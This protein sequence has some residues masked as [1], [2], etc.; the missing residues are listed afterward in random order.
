MAG[1]QRLADFYDARSDRQQ[2]FLDLG[3]LFS[4]TGGLVYA[5]GE[6]AGPV[7]RSY[8]GYAGLIPLIMADFNANE[9]TRDLFFAGDWGVQMILGR[10]S[11]L[12]TRT[13][14]L[15]SIQQEYASFTS[16]TSCA[17]LPAQITAVS[18]WRAGDDKTA[19]LAALL[20]ASAACE[21]TRHDL[22]VLVQAI[23]ESQFTDA[24]LSR[25]LAS[26]L[27]NL[28]RSLTERDNTLRTT[29]AEALTL[30]IASPLRALDSLASGDDVQAAV[31]QIRLQQAIDGLIVDLW[32]PPSLPESPSPWVQTF[33]VGD[34]VLARLGAAQTSGAP[35][36]EQ[37]ARAVTWLQGLQSEHRTAAVRYNRA[38]TLT[39]EVR[40]AAMSDQLRFSSTNGR[41]TVRFGSADAVAPTGSQQTP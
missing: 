4:G 27:V 6:G 16:L 13:V 18:G 12:Q 17:G 15:A 14:S 11:T 20:R 30:V 19:V 38:V 37:V 31:N 25:H 34:P 10:Y 35:S 23:R 29:P 26:D 40:L 33:Q 8:W 22:A 7:T 39:R 2:W 9:P 3:A 36:R 21:A 28:D 32:S 5:A 24:D 1:A 41:I